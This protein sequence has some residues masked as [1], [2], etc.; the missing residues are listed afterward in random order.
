MFLRAMVARIYRPGCK[1]DYMLILEGP[2]GQLKS[3]ACR[4]LAW[5]DEYFSDALPELTNIKECSIHLQGKW[6]IE[7]PELHAFNRAEATLL[8]SFLSRTTEQFRP[9]YGRHEIAQPRQGTF[10]GTSNKDAYLRDETGGRR[11]WP[12]VCGAIDLEALERDRDALLAE[13]VTEFKT[14]VPW[15]PDPAFEQKYITPEQDKRYEFDPWFEAIE[16]WLDQTTSTRITALGIARAAL[17]MKIDRADAAIGRRIAAIM[18]K[19]GWKLDHD[20]A[21]SYFSKTLV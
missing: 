10:I 18:R 6:L 15:W 7:I 14:E 2:Q 16:E 9:P 19:L 4:I 21:G 20:R 13:A 12:V 5:K 1:A 8:K 11:F 17:D 3:T